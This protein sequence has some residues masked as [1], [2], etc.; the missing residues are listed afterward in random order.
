MKLGVLIIGSLYWDDCKIREKWRCDRLQMESAVH[1]N[2]PIRYG[3]RSHSRGS[4]FTMVFSMDLVRQNKFGQ[5]IVVPCKTPVHS[6]EDLIKE[7]RHLWAAESK[8]NETDCKSTCAGWGRVVLLKNPHRAI[9]SDVLSG[10]TQHVSGERCYSKCMKT[11]KDEKAVVDNSGFLKIPWPES[12]DGTHLPLDA[13]L[14][15]ATNPTIVGGNYP[16]AP[17]IADAWNTPKGKGFIDYF[18]ENRAHRITTI[19]DI[20]IEVR[21]SELRSSRAY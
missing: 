8:K 17:Q 3:R 10:W 2:A 9:A 1:V 13:L 20:E 15:T 5:A 16:S 19:H 6:N 21:L 7:A 14:A 11:G 12:E 18:W 4:A